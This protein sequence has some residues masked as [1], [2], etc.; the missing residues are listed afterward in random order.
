M[1]TH[2][3]KSKLQFQIN[4]QNFKFFKNLNMR[5]TSWSWLIRCVNMK[6]IRLV[7]WKIQSGHDSI[8]TDK[9]KPV[10]APPP[11]P[12]PPPLQLCWSGGYNV[13]AGGII[14][15]H[16]IQTFLKKSNK[17]NWSTYWKQ[18]KSE[19]SDNCDRPCNL[20]FTR[21]KSILQPVITYDVEIDTWPW[22]NNR[23]TL[24]CS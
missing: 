8:Q 24:Q 6:W 3:T 1:D 2:K 16:E 10:Y 20:K 19:R 18:S 12:T 11:H 14:M 4:C 13:E 23:E 7:L 22:K 9:V 17:T 15:W 21:F 5:H